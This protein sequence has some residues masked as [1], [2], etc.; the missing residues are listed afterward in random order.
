MTYKITL[1]QQAQL[2]R[3]IKFHLNICSSIDWEKEEIEPFSKEQAGPKEKVWSERELNYIPSKLSTLL[4]IHRC[5]IKYWRFKQGHGR[6]QDIILYRQW[7]ESYPFVQSILRGDQDAWRT[8]VKTFATFPYQNEV[9]KAYS[10]HTYNQV[11]AECDIFLHCIDEVIPKKIQKITKKGH[12]RYHN[13]PKMK[14]YSLYESYVYSCLLKITNDLFATLPCEVIY[15]NGI[16]GSKDR[17]QPILSTVIE[18]NLHQDNSQPLLAIQQHRHIVS[19][20][21][22]SGFDPIK[23]VYSPIV[24]NKK[25]V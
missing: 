9:L 18:R 12:L 21:K 8:A 14:R 3:L 20:K 22:R 10:L 17:H 1:T 16:V 6:K 7:E 24:L 15:L 13:M 11:T 19:F 23:R 5:K 25:K 2:D 4:R